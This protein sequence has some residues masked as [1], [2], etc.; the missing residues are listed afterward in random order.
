M[1]IDKF[2][3]YLKN[4][5]RYSEHTLTAYQKDLESFS[6]YSKEIYEIDDLSKINQ[7]VI[8]SW[9]V[10]LMRKG[11]SNNSI[12]RKIASLKS[13]YKFLENDFINNQK[14][15]NPT[16][17]LIMPK[18]VKKLPSFVRESE[19]KTL[20]NSFENDDFITQRDKAIIS[21]LYATG[22]RRSELI[23]VNLANINFDDAYIK[24]LG[25]RKK[26]RIIPINKDIVEILRQYW[27]L[28]KE[29]FGL[30]NVFFVTQKGK[31]LYPKAVYNI[32]NKY[33]SQVSTLEQKSPHT[34]RHTFATHLLNNGAE[35]KAIQ[36]LLGHN[37]LAATQ[38]YTHTT[39]HKL[40]D[41]YIKAH[42]KANNK[43]K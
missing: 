15:I 31:K 2:I 6:V 12:N 10:Y 22:I 14:V 29:K 27:E 4:E 1:I 38:V 26:E 17:H 20:L 11:L 40:K 35:L 19:M 8:R 28:K 42:P 16:K 23:N 5:K 39:I 24:V 34:L 33:L 13:F 37:S 41:A 43:Y 18:K 32:V 25:K 9:T 7:D 21:L 30:S 36:D 3:T